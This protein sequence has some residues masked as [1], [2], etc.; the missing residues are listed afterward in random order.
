MDCVLQQVISLM[1]FALDTHTH[2]HTQTGDGHSTWL[3]HS[4]VTMM[5]KAHW[6]ITVHRMESVLDHCLDLLID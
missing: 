6:V 1:S 3:A 4:P 5:D 2:T